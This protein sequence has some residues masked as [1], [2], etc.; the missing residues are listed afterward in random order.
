MFAS[1]ILQAGKL[2]TTALPPQTVNCF[3]IPVSGG[4]SKSVT[5]F[6]E[7]QDVFLLTLV[8]RLKIHAVFSSGPLWEVL[9]FRKASPDATGSSSTETTS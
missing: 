3:L 9:F 1:V 2:G 5:H 8:V 7:I 6:Q 4:Q